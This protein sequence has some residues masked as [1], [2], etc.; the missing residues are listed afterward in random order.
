M[1]ADTL[2]RNTG[3]S[4]RAALRPPVRSRAVRLW[5]Q[6]LTLPPTACQPPS[7]QALDRADPRRPHK[8]RSRGAGTVSGWCGCAG[9]GPS[10]ALH[11]SCGPSAAVARASSP[12][13]SRPS[14]RRYHLAQRRSGPAADWFQAAVRDIVKQADTQAP[15]L[16]AVHL[17]PGGG[18]PR[19]QTFGVQEAVVGAPEVGAGAGAGALGS[20]WGLAGC[21]LLG[22][23]MPHQRRPILALVTN[24]RSRPPPPP[25]R[26]PCSCGKALLSTWASPR[27]MS[28]FWCSVCRP[29]RP[30]ARLRAPST[31]QRPTSSSSSS[32]AARRAALAAH[33]AA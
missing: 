3:H 22:M 5:G 23:V 19:L 30:P 2:E 13:P 33:A 10:S 20:G 16:Q 31:P 8:Q 32:R 25:A 12:L 14:S 26:P 24:P 18:S 27:Q 4:A 28:S 21:W 17:P 29:P 7:A 11:A 9:G 6:I 15:F 1:D